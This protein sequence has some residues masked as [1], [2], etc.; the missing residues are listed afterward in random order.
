L[1]FDFTHHGAIP[2]ET[3]ENAE[4][5]TNRRL[6]DDSPVRAYETTIEFARS[7]GA[8]ALFG[9][10]Y[11]EL[12]RVV[13]IGD[14]SKE[15]CG[16]THVPHTGKIALVRV[17][18]EGSI[19]SGLRRVDALVGPDGLRHINEERRLLDEVVAA[20]GGGDPRAA[21]D[22]I[23]KA[24]ERMKQLETELGKIRK[25]DQRQEL[26]RMADSVFDLDG[27]KV[28]VDF[29]RGSDAST[30]REMAL[31]L[32]GHLAGDPAA[33]VLATVSSGKSN[34]VVALTSALVERGITAS[35]VAEPIAHAAGGRAG[36]KP[37]LAIGGGPKEIAESELLPT[38]R[39]RL[40]ELL[41]G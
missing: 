27:I 40:R 34:V 18:G 10:K 21:P 4:Y 11:G 23:R 20:I 38:V 9:E 35:A 26:A 19:G 3:L 12:V 24:M 6:A 33:I 14:Y 31:Q 1:R 15:L 17:L 25:A 7:Q 36:G 32:K 37:D 5:T 41:A 28:L 2:S 30:L 22:R 29:E 8:I 16:G 39:A 13:E